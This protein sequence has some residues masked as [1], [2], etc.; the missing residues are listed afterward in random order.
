MVSG[1]FKVDLL[2]SGQHTLQL[3]K[4]GYS[5]PRQTI[6]IKVNEVLNMHE[7]MQRLFIPDTMVRFGPAATDV[8]TGR[9]TRKHPNGDVELE[10]R[11]GVTI[12]IPADT[13]LQV[14]PLND[15]ETQ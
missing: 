15:G 9:L 5:L 4:H 12:E 6:A 8:Y 7:K 11:P 3:T 2:S 1:E 14:R 10:V 13:I